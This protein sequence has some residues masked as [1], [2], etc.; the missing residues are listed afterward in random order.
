MGWWYTYAMR[1]EIRSVKGRLK[2]GGSPSNVPFPSAVVMFRP[3]PLEI[4]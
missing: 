1:S 3:S 2:F 4:V